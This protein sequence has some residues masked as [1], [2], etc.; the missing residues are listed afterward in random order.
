MQ[1]AMAIKDTQNL[2]LVQQYDLQIK[3][4]QGQLGKVLE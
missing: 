2:Q 1:R 4:L 3:D